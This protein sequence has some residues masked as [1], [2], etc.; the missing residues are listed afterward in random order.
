MARVVWRILRATLSQLEQ[1]ATLSQLVG[2]N[3][4]LN[5]AHELGWGRNKAA[6]LILYCVATEPGCGESCWRD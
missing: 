1:L 5:N 6:V 3:A 2:S 4:T